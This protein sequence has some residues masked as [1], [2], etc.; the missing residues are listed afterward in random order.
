MAKHLIIARH[1][2]T[3]DD[4]DALLRVGLRTD[5]PLSRSGI[6]Q[7]RA[8]GAHLAKTFPR[9]VTIASGNLQRSVR[10]AEEIR[11]ALPFPISVER[12]DSLNELDYGEDDGKPEEEVRM[13]LGENALKRWDEENV[14]PA[15]WPIDVDAVCERWR[16]LAALARADL[17]E[18]KAMLCV[19]SNGT[20]R[21]AP[22]ALSATDAPARLKLATAAYGVI[23]LHGDGTAET[24]GWNIRAR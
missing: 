6:A 18:E 19:T 3:F 23:A 16:R 11:A 8:L 5:I 21:F 9:I 2:N 14:P 7:A 12:M 20:A 24:L 22:S 1:G 15:S 10:T 4:G 13:R 17:K